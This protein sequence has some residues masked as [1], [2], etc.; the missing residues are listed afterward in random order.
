M[1]TPSHKSLTFDVTQLCRDLKEKWI[2]WKSD[3]FKFS[4][5]LVQQRKCLAIQQLGLFDPNENGKDT[6]S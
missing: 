4:E 6:Y 3:L 5:L 1:T 2:L